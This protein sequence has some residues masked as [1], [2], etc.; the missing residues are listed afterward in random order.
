MSAVFPGGNA[1][2]AD[3]ELINV[4]WPGAGQGLSPGRKLSRFPRQGLCRE[5][6]F[7]PVHFPPIRFPRRKRTHIEQRQH[8]EQ[9]AAPPRRAAGVAHQR[10]ERRVRLHNK[11]FSRILELFLRSLHLF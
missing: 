6:R 8:M 3:P 7:S 10:R 5:K 4:S 2:F 1:D 9:R 11:M